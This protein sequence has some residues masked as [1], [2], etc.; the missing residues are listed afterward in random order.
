MLFFNFTLG[1]VE[2]HSFPLV[3]QCFAKFPLYPVLSFDQAYSEAPD[4]GSHHPAGVTRGLDRHV[5]G[6]H[7]R[8]SNNFQRDVIRRG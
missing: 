3:L 5:H 2:N 1:E 7:A 8:T 4:V 6:H